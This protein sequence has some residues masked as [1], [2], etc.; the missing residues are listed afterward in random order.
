[1]CLI[2]TDEKNIAV[3]RGSALPKN[4]KSPLEIKFAKLHCNKNYDWKFFLIKKKYKQREVY[5]LIHLAD[6]VENKK[7]HI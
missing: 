6:V 2:L 7:V 3:Y 4:L 5:V 1:M